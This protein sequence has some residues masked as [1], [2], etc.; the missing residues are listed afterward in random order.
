M[1]YIKENCVARSLNTLLAM[2]EKQKTND[3]VIIHWSCG[4]EAAA[5]LSDAIHDWL[6]RADHPDGAKL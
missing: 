2:I 6:E 3:L 5:A 1:E 4:K